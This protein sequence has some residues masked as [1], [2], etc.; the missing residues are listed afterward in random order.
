MVFNRWIVFLV[1]NPFKNTYLY[2]D[3]CFIG[4][5]VTGESNILAC[6]QF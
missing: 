6:E 2:I 3:A 1:L 5:S 4:K